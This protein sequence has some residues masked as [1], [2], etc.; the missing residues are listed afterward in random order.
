M[1]V[2]T[3]LRESL[4]ATVG[5][6]KAYRHLE[7]QFDKQ[8]NVLEA[9]KGKSEARENRIHELTR[10]LGQSKRSHKRQE[11][12]ARQREVRLQRALEEVDRYKKKAEEARTIEKEGKKV[13]QSDQNSLAL[14]NKKL[15]KQKAELLL[16]FKK[17]MKLIDVL[18]KQKLHMEAARRL[19]FT[20]EE[21]VKVLDMPL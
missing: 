6:Q 17:Q 11:G 3:E 8:R 9:I 19:A 2:E 5:M 15:Q 18:K 13:M 21:F 4:A 16:A 12:D 7:A 10:E 1:E 14:E 20:E